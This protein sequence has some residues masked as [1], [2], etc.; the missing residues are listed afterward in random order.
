MDM[1]AAI[2]IALPA[3]AAGLAG[4]SAQAGATSPGASTPAAESVQA[5]AGWSL[6]PSKGAANIAAAGLAALS[7]EGTAEHYHAHLDVITD[8]KTIPVP[9]EIGVSFGADGQP[10]GISALHT[11]DG[12]GVVHIEAPTAGRTYTLGQLLTEWGVLDGTGGAPGSARSSAADWAVY[13]NGAKQQ[14]SPRDVVLSP[15]AEIAL[16]HGQESA[17]SIPSTYA[18]PAGL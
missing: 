18:F 15:H 8:G 17:S 5:Q 9:A 11:H 2:L 1:K 4:C 6:A 14:G 13:V 10:N 12:S 16:V 3:L 7:E